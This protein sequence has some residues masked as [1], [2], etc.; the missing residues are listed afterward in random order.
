MDKATVTAFIIENRKKL[1]PN[2][3]YTELDIQEFLLSAP[4]RSA[5]ALQTLRLRSPF[6]AMLLSAFLGFFGVDRFVAGEYV[7]GALKLLSG[8]G[9]Y[10]WWIL[11]ALTAKSR[12]RSRN[13]KAL[14]QA[15][16]LPAPDA[17]A[18]AELSPPPPA[19][20][21]PVREPVKEDPVPGPDI[22]VTS[23]A[24]IFLSYSHRD[25]E[26]LMPLFSALQQAGLAVWYDAGIRAGAE[27]EEEIILQLSNAPGFLF[28]VSEHSLTSTNCRDEL[29]QARKREKKFINVLVED[30]D[31][32]DPRFEW[33]DFRYSR[34]QQISAYSMPIDEVV[35]RIKR[36]LDL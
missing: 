21:F 34:Y 17:P 3:R 18:A 29:Y 5:V 6:G 28:F 25:K 27:W 10:V 19:A 12:C 35:A 8:G 1:F 14:F 30:I 31:L 2:K 36:G 15:I 4:Q 13:C 26:R 11:D 23:N 22:P 33:F 32:S 24:D 9:F 7:L 16:G 20:D